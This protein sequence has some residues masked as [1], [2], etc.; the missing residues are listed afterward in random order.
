MTKYIS[1]LQLKGGSG[2]TTISINLTGFLLS[3][4]KKVLAVDADLPQ[5]TFSAWCALYKNPKL[6]YATARNIDELLAVL[7]QAE[8]QFDYVVIDSP[9]RMA[10]MMNAIMYISDLVLLPVAP[11]APEIWA[12]GD[13]FEV[14]K[15]ALNARDKQLNLRIVWNKFKGTK[16]ENQTRQEVLDVYGYPEIPVP[17][18]TYVAYNEVTGQGTHVI[19][20]THDKAKAQFESFGKEV[21]KALK[22]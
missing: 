3:K 7:E 20:Y 1:L 2:K 16:K 10:E 13:M 4:K 18:N 21:L 15:D 12:M 8:G 14:I 5:A 9:P 19:E 17:I 11:S 22:G 6:E